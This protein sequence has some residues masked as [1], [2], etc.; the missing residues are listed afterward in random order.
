MACEK[1]LF[2]VIA[3][4]LSNAALSDQCQ[5]RIGGRTVSIEYKKDAEF[6]RYAGARDRVL[7]KW[8]RVCPGYVVLRYMTPTLTGKQREPFCLNFDEGLGAYSP[9]S[10]G[11]RDGY[12][13]CSKPGQICN[14]INSAKDEA[15]AVAGTVAALVGV[16]NSAAA[17]TGVTAVAH[18]S[19]A[20]ILSGT[21]GYVAGTLGGPVATTLGLIGGAP[22]ATAAA[23]S[24]VAV[25]GA[26]WLCK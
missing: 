25:G 4:V 5:S 16:T 11:E 3:L 18:S 22:V 15:V 14:S 24:V 21:S 6:R 13:Q 17:A 8:R 26:V 23:V 10:L 2:A 1:L 19:G 12:W 7:S 20:Y 9:L